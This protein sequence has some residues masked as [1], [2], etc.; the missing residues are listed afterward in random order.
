[1]RHSKRRDWS[2]AASLPH[3]TGVAA[4]RLSLDQLTIIGRHLAGICSKFRP[5]ARRSPPEEEPQASA[6]EDSGHRPGRL[7]AQYR[8][9]LQP[10]VARLDLGAVVEPEAR[11]VDETALRVDADAARPRRDDLAQFFAA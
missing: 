4:Y 8:P 1:M 9:N 2:I 3:R 6:A 5:F 10:G 7:H 11:H